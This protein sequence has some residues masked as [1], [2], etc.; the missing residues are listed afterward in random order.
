[1]RNSQLFRRAGSEMGESAALLRIDGGSHPSR[2]LPA[3]YFERKV[4]I[5][6]GETVD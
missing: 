6:I 5:I 3:V 2:A 1:M 4:V